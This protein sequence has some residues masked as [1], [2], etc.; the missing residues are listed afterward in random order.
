MTNST[1]WKLF[2]LEIKILS[3]FSPPTQP[4]ID[5]GNPRS[6]AIWFP[7]STIEQ[8]TSLFH[9]TV[10]SFITQTLDFSHPT[11]FRLAD[12]FPHI[13][14]VPVRALP[15]S[16]TKRCTQLMANIF[17][18][19]L[20]SSFFLSL[21]CTHTSSQIENHCKCSACP[22]GWFLKFWDRNVK[23]KLGSITIV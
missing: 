10:K 2:I 7:C 6:L 1:V 22:L 20:A 14:T 11:P 16:Q 3:S 18:A 21:D 17:R 13:D 15:L 9:S 23:Q 4:F 5:V 8:H 12:M 19:W